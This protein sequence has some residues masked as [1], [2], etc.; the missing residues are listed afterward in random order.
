MLIVPGEKIL[1][2]PAGIVII[3]V[4]LASGRVMKI[5]LNSLINE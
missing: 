4:W 5:K 2:I 1:G 3:S